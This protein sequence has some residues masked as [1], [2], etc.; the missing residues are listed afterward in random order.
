MEGIARFGVK[1]NDRG[2]G[3]LKKRWPGLASLPQ[4]D[5]CAAPTRVER[6]ASLSRETGVELWAKRDDESAELYGG[7]KVRKLEWLLGEAQ[8]HGCRTLVT[9][10]ALG[11]HHVLA[12][13]TWGRELGMQTRA[14]LVPQPWTPHVE[15]NLRALLATGA[16][17]TPIKDLGFLPAAM[18]REVVLRR[19][20]GDRPQRI[21]LGGSCPTGALGYVEAGLELAEQIDQGECPEPDAVYVA[22]G[23]GGTAAGLAIGFAAAGLTTRVVGV[24]VT[25]SRV[26]NRLSLRLLVRGTARRLR[27]LDPHFPTIATAAFELLEIDERFFGNGYGTPHT[28]AAHAMLCASREGITLEQTYT[29]RAFAAM[30]SD[31]RERGGTRLFVVTLSG[32]DLAPRVAHAP[33][34][35]PWARAMG[36]L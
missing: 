35:P 1:T 10:G 16:H 3:V 33:E 9:A 24:R 20:K 21:E 6:L 7:N 22:L 27:A 15:Q 2:M 34:A 31:G 12:T 32:A 17:V 11:S 29:G 26:I 8:A 36:A 28:E 23:T 25:D 13:A 19:L 5:L 30:L 4:L 14:I 18:A